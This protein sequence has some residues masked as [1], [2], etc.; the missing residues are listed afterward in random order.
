MEAKPIEIEQAEMQ[1]QIH[2]QYANIMRA[3]EVAL[4]KLFV[5]KLFTQLNLT[6]Y[7]VK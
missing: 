7:K 5:N 6:K 4:K 1:F 2:H 3:N